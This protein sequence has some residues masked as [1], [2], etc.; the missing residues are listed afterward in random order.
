MN[1]PKVLVTGFANS[2]T[3][4]LCQLIVEMGFSPGDPTDLKAGDVHNPY[5][6]WEYLPL[7][8][9][10][11]DF[12]DFRAQFH[13]FLNS[14][15]V[16]AA[17]ESEQLISQVQLLAEVNNIEVYKDSWLPAFY[18]AFPAT[19]RYVIIRR[20]WWEVYRSGGYQVVA[21]KFFQTFLDYWMMVDKMC[22]NVPCL[23]VQYERFGENFDREAKRI[24]QFL[25][26]SCDVAK[27]RWVWRPGGER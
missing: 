22:K 24:A 26:I 15:P 11:H 5:G 6:Y 3:S 17:P 7:R 19:S 21:S 8:Y 2:G 4:F 13:P 1:L 12:I 23:Y 25:G 16:R 9:E 20:E 10:I 14:V 27:L 18:W